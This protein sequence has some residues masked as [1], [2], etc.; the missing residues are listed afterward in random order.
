M[1]VLSPYLY[2]GSTIQFNPIQSNSTREEESCVCACCA[3]VHAH[4]EKKKIGGRA[5]GR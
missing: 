3:I 4:G 1:C 5:A 2:H